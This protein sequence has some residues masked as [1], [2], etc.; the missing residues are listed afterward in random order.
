MNEIHTTQVLI[1][2]EILLF[3]I[4]AFYVLIFGVA[5]F[6]FTLADVDDEGFVGILSRLLMITIPNA[7]RSS[8]KAIFGEKVYNWCHGTVRYAVYERNPIL[9]CLYLAII[10]AAFLGWLVYGAPLLPTKFAGTIHI[11]GGYIGV[12]ICQYTFYKA[13]ST[14]PGTIT[15]DNVNCFAHQPY[16]GL[17]FTSGLYCTTCKVEKVKYFHLFD[18]LL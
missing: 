13:C 9:Q 6:W 10:N 5:I 17:L 2:M 14:G 3:G 12:A 11:Y 8:V 1:T 4:I 18:I 15:A 7:V 16:D